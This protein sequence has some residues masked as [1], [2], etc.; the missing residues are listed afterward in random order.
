MSV[1]KLTTLLLAV[2]LTLLS[3]ATVAAPDAA[4]TKLSGCY[5]ENISEQVLCGTLAVPENYDL[6]DGQTS[7]TYF[8]KQGDVFRA[9]LADGT[10][11]DY[12]ATDAP[13]QCV[14]LNDTGY[15]PIP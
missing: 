8:A 4:A 2:P 1:I 12:T 9:T 5:L 11:Q 15:V 7:G 14:L 3:N 10:T 13:T 6:A